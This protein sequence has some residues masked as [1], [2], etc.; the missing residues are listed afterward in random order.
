MYF[1]CQRMLTRSR[2]QVRARQDRN[3]NKK[4]NLA[5]LLYLINNWCRWS[6]SNRHGVCTPK[7]FKSFAS[8]I[9]PHRLIWRHHPDSNWGIRVLQTLALPRGDGA[10]QLFICT[11]KIFCY[12]KKWS[13]RRDSNSRHLP[14]QGNALPLSHSRIILVGTIGIEP[15]TICL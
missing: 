4:V 7:D 5:S 6:D 15:M 11:H 14:W 2:I 8:A 3:E 13:G 10:R 12:I 1:G 9:S